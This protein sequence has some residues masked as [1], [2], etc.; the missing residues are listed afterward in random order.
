LA[1]LVFDVG[2]PTATAM[3]PATIASSQMKKAALPGAVSSNH[4]D[5][6]SE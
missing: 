1:R 5:T 3:M 6:E 2:Q 4:R